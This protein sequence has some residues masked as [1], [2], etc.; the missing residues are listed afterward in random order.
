MPVD[1]GKG[2]WAPMGGIDGCWQTLTVGDG[3][4]IECQYKGGELLC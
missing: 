4:T 3:V 2:N 1:R